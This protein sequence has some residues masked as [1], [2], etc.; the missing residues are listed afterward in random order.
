MFDIEVGQQGPA[1]EAAC[2]I[3]NSAVLLLVA[4]RCP[5][6]RPTE[7]SHFPAIKKVRG[8]DSATAPK[9][10]P[11]QQLRRDPF[12]AQDPSSLSIRSREPIQHGHL[13]RRHV[14]VQGGHQPRGCPRGL[15]PNARPQGRLRAPVDDDAVHQVVRGR[16]GH[17]HRGFPGTCSVWWVFVQHPGRA[18]C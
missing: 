9:R 15:H 6:R 14:P 17:L 11:R 2:C 16:Q 18:C 4:T 3:D 5:A 13:P 12:F 7:V 8:F 1:R 10:P